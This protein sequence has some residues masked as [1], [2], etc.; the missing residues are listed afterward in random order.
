M[1]EEPEERIYRQKIL[2]CRLTDA[3]K[4]RR[5]DIQ[6]VNLEMQTDRRD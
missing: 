4:T 3:L 5:G 6:I 2:K 1:T